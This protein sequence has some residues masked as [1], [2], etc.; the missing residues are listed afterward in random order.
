M[1]FYTPSFMLCGLYAFANLTF[2]P[3]SRLRRFLLLA[4][5]RYRY[6]ALPTNTRHGIP[7]APIHR[8]P[9][10]S[11]L[12]DDSHTIGTHASGKPRARLNER[13]S[14]LTFAL[15]VLFAFAVCAVGG[16]VVGS[17]ILAYIMAGVFKAAKYHM[18]T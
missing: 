1:I 6:S 7:L 13:R 3:E 11:H 18:S 4:P 9:T 10:P 12:H 17:A 8:S 2:T 14:R 5:P 15:I 16:A